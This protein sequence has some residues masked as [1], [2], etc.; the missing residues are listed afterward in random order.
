MDLAQPPTHPLVRLSALLLPRTYTN[1]LMMEKQE[2][3][4]P[5]TSQGQTRESQSRCLSQRAE[6]VVGSKLF[7]DLSEGL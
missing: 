2:D 5:G 3:L 4:Q 6:R 1:V 7:N